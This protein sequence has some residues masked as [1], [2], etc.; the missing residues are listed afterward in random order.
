MDIEIVED[1]YNPL[2]ERRE[3]KFLVK[4]PREATPERFRVRQVLREKFNVDLDRLIVIRLSS[5]TG[6]NT[7]EG[8]CHI[9]DNLENIK[10]F[11]PKHVLL[12]NLPPEER[13]KLR[14]EK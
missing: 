3:V 6:L 14:E 2:L 5:K 1:F 8:I 13:A 9:Y 12:K 11:V 4:H 10:Y 7:S